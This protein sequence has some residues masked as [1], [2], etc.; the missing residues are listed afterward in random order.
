[1]S[2]KGQAATPKQATV[3]HYQTSLS[4]IRSQVDSFRV[5]G[6]E[7]E[8]EIYQPDQNYSNEFLQV[9]NLGVP[10]ICSID[11]DDLTQL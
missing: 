6:G 10:G 9:T 4:H 8:F 7:I 2:D 1:M 3:P 11:W 5:S